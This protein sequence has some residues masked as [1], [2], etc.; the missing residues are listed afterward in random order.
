MKA[1]GVFEDNWNSAK[2]ICLNRG[3]SRSSKSFSVAQIAAI[4]LVSGKVG[5]HWPVDSNGFFSIVRKTSPALRA[6]TYRDF[7]EILAEAGWL[8]VVKENLTTLTFVCGNRTVEFFSIDNETKVRGRKRKH[9]FIDEANELT[10]EDIKQ[11]LIRTTGRCFFAFNPS[12]PYHVLKTFYEDIR[13]HE[14]GDVEVIVS[15]Y[16]NNP[17]LEKEVVR[18]IELLKVQDMDT[19]LVFGAGQYTQLRGIIFTNWR[20]GNLPKEAKLI[21]YGLDFGFSNDVSALVACYLSGG[22]LYIDCLIYERGLTN[23]DISDRM[24]LENVGKS[25]TIIADSSEPKS[26]EELYRLGWRG[27]KAANKPR[28]S[29]NFTIDLMKQYSIVVC[30]DFVAKEF[31]TYKWR[32]DRQGNIINEPVDFNNH[33]IDAARYIIGDKLNKQSNYAIKRI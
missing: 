28:G 29:V 3:S 5:E 6:S 24:L 26:I 16:I 11:L 23:K 27:I 30:S 10:S 9:L 17:Y 25:D 22:E 7:K 33:A 2:K 31:E 14:V 21:G 8:S 12:N 32:T 18:E 13:Q 1:T 4:W 19:W 15:T 20:R